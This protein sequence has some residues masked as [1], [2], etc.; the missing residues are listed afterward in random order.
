ME[1]ENSPQLAAHREQISCVAFSRDCRFAISGSD[2]S[3]VAIWD[4]ATG[5]CERL[6][7]GHGGCVCAVALSSSGDLAVS[8]EDT[9]EA[10]LW[11]IGKGTF[12]GNLP[13]EYGANIDFRPDGAHVAFLP[14]DRIAMLVKH[15]NHIAAWDVAAR[16]NLCARTLTDGTE[17]DHLIPMAVGSCSGHSYLLTGTYNKLSLTRLRDSAEWIS[18]V[19]PRVKSPLFRSQRQG[20]GVS[21]NLIHGQEGGGASC[22]SPHAEQQNFGLKCLAFSGDGSTAASCADDCIKIWQVPTLECLHVLPTERNTLIAL[23][24]DGK[25]AASEDRSGARFLWDLGSGQCIRTAE[26]HG[27]AFPER[28]DN[29]LAIA[30]A[31]DGTRVFFGKRQNPTEEWDITSE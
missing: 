25:L 29:S 8:M 28:F 24:E 26:G 20:M 6:L 5:H 10:L 31:P 21:W 19:S 23:S 7:R 13:G 12:L 3:G 16:L 22:K 1:Q 2:D 27:K 14:G 17:D 11:D 18:E 30:F 15:Y 9:S 4:T